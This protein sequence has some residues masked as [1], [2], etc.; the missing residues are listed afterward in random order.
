L[1]GYLDR[2]ALEVRYLLG[3]LSEE[4]EKSF[5]NRYFAD[6]QAFEQLQIAEGEVIDAYVSERLPAQAHKHLEERLAKSPRLRERV[7]FAR[8]FAGAIP[9]IRLDQLPVA[10][11][12]LPSP[13]AN[14]PVTPS[15]VP[16]LPWWK[17]LFKGSFERQ[18]ALTM[19]LAAC[20]VLVLL[21]GTAVVVQSVRLRRESQRLAAERA[22][23]ER[24]REELNRLSAEQ[25]TK[26][27]VRA[28]ELEVQQRRNA[29]ELA[30]IE[31]LGQREKQ[32][33]GS[34]Q[35]NAPTPTMATVFLYAGSL[36][37]GGGPEE[38]KIPPGASQI[39]LGLV[40]ETATYRNYYVVIK[41]AQKKEVF[42]KK[43]RLSAGKTLFLKVPTSQL[44]PGNYAADV[45]GV[46]PSGSTEHVRTYD[47][48][49]V[50]D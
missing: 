13:K 30:R 24:Q 8:T 28:S 33:E 42:A 14:P 21:G 10:P 50:T 3:E 25:N 22:T 49:V 43:V 1:A 40:L 39:L 23:I 26:I 48:R 2:T 20:V 29:E 32:K 35:G 44:K 11:A 9:D 5:E 16:T 18:P 19:A 46:T 4:E 45:S 31:E 47:F 36:R 6:D 34:N 41:D 17:G 37:S 27:A 12:E 38:V 7:A 15:P